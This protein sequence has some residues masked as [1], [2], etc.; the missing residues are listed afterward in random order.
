MTLTTIET[1]FL[2]TRE[3]YNFRGQKT[4]N[5]LRKRC[6]DTTQGLFSRIAIGQ[7]RS[8]SA[9]PTSIK[10]EKDIPGLPEN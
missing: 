3:N 2:F 1:T 9:K 5:T 7:C 6:T 10:K 4:V 8:I